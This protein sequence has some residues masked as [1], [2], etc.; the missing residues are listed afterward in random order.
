MKKLI[1]YASIFLL[2]VSLVVPSLSFAGGISIS[3]SA[4]NLTTGSNAW[5]NTVNAKP[6]DEIAY[7]TKVYNNTSA[8]VAGL[9][10]RVAL[11]A[12]LQYVNGTSK[13][14]YKDAATGTDKVAALADTIVSNGTSINDIPSDYFVYV[15]YKVR[16]ASNASTGTY[17]AGNQVFGT[18]INVSTNNA[19]VL[20]SGGSV[21]AADT[22][23]TV[24]TQDS[25]TQQSGTAVIASALYN[26]TKGE[27][28][29]SVSTSAN[30]GDEIMYRIKL[31]NTGTT[32]LT[33]LNARIQ[34]PS[35]FEYAPDYSRAIFT[36]GGVDKQIA[37]NDA[38][39]GN[40]TTLPINV[41]VSNYIY[42]VYKVK[43]ASN[44]VTG[45]YGTGNQVWGNGLNVSANNAT[46]MV[47]GSAVVP[48]TNALSIKATA[49]NE[50]QAATV[51]YTNSVNANRGDVIKFHV[52][53]ANTSKDVLKNTKITNSLPANMEYVAGS[54]K[55]IIGGTTV[56]VPDNKTVSLGDLS[57]GANG[58]L[59]FSAK[60][61]SD[62]PA[63][64]EQLTYAANGI[65]D[66]ISQ[67]SS[68]VNIYLA[69]TGEKLP[70]TGPIAT[71]LALIVL[72]AFISVASY[73]YLK[74]S[75]ALKSAA[76]LIQR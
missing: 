38:I 59:E 54:A 7:S 13:L 42:I 49:Y 47:S 68:V 52:A 53:F 71:I 29:Y 64:I 35:A 20:V 36:E 70:S 4:A 69:G 45:T 51:A 1:N 26:L 61:K 2:L 56:S 65:A 58:I 6:G 15:T 31:T 57:V 10:F 5:S 18:G 3:T 32:P 44:A 16:V 43:V 9:S 75:N 67:V 22:Q 27:T 48:V 40:G 19:N 14:Y 11:P 46:V 33:G 17:A 8:P 60:V 66:G 74:E 24:T 34:L 30:P 25:T 72:A 37:L 23:T 62:T 55:T 41:S 50:T 39:I 21:V 63:N 12:T 28:N 76:K 73:M